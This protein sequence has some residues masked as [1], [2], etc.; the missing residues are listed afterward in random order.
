MIV[1][2]FTLAAEHRSE[3]KIAQQTED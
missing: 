2:S 1:G 3:L